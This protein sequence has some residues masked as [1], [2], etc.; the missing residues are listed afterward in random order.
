[1]EPELDEQLTPFS[2]LT[3]LKLEASQMS[4]IHKQIK[5]LN[6]TLL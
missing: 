5:E 1:M 3:Y 2:I 4:H 6:Q